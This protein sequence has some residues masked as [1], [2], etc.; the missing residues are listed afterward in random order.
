ME[1]GRDVAYRVGKRSLMLG[2]MGGA[3]GVVLGMAR[4]ASVPFY[5][6]SMMTNYTMMGLVYFCKWVAVLWGLYKLNWSM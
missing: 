3:F 2:G 6:I 5:S 1:E 4:N